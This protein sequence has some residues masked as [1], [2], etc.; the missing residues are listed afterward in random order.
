[1]KKV[2]SVLLVVCLM[3]GLTIQAGALEYTIDAPGD[4]DYCRT[5]P[6]T[7]TVG[8]IIAMWPA[9]VHPPFR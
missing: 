7:Q 4:P 2:W 9:V 8:R 1:M 6:C 3:A 5:S